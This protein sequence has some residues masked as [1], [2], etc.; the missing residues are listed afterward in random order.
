M[1]IIDSAKQAAQGLVQ[2]AMEKLVPLAPDSWIPGGV[3]DPLIARKHGL[4][5]KPVSRL[6][7]PLKV[8]GGAHFSAEFR[9]DGMVYAA[10]AYATIARGALPRSTARRRRPHRASCW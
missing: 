8:T 6:D 5:G 4:I 1:S 3:P 9:F 10:L 2:G 7:G